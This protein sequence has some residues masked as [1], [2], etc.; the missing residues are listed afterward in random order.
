MKGMCCG[1]EVDC[2]I[3]CVV[4]VYGGYVVCGCGGVCIMCRVVGCMRC[5]VCNVFCGMCVIGGCCCGM[6][7]V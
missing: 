5:G 3:R 7:G 2:E 4:Y 1:W 6:D